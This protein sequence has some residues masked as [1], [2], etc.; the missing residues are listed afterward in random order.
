MV[1]FE[2][3]R[4]FPLPPA[5]L[6]AKLSDARFLAQCVPGAEAVKKS[7]PQEAVCVVRPGFSFARGT[8]EVTLRVLE[9]VPGQSV[10]LEVV[11]KGI[12][13]TSTVEAVAK[14]VPQGD[15]THVHWV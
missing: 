6:G 4:D 13:S 8:L 11:G 14:L 10:R 1:Q 5:E 2:G 3:D 15:G 7:E 12:G 9:T